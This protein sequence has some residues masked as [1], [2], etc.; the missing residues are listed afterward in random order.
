[1][2]VLKPTTT[3][4]PV[5]DLTWLDKND[6]RVLAFTKK[7]GVEGGGLWY[8]ED[9]AT[10]WVNKTQALAD[11]SGTDIKEAVEVVGI[12]TP[13][14]TVGVVRTGSVVVFGTGTVIW[15]SSDYGATYT[16]K[17]TGGWRGNA[18]KMIKVHPWHAD[19]MLVLAKRPNCTNA[20]HALVECPHDLMLTQ[21]LYGALTWQNLTQ[22]SNGKIAGFVDFDW[23][24]Q[25]CADR[26]DPKPPSPTPSEY[27]IDCRKF[28]LKD[29][30]VLATMYEKPG[31]YDHP[32]DKDVH[33]VTTHDLFSNH[34]VVVRCGNM[35]EVIGN[36]VFLA[37]S[38]SCPTDIDGSP[39]RPHQSFSGV[40][41]YTS[42]D[43]AVS[44]EQGCVPVALKQE[45][46]EMLT[47]HDSTGVQ[48]IVDFKVGG[49]KGPSLFASS[50]YTAGPRDAIYT[51]S[52]TNVYR[53]PM[54]MGS[55]YARVEGLPG[56]YIA[57]QLLP[58][59]GDDY[60]YDIDTGA[61][62]VESR[63][64]F[65]G[66]G[67]WARIPAPKTFNSAKCNRCT[68]PD[69]FLHLRGTSTWASASAS[70]PAVYS[71]P[72]APGI[73]MATGV[74]ASSGGGLEDDD[75][76]L[77]TWLSTDGGISWKD[78]A[79]G[80]WVYEYADFGSTIVM[81]RHSGWRGEAAD[82]V[83]FSVDN[84]ACWYSVPLETAMFVE[85][86][87]IEPD[88][89]RPRVVVHGSAC[90][91]SV[92][93]KCSLDATNRTSASVPGIMYMV[94]VQELLAGKMSQCTEAEYEWWFV[95]ESSG[96][97]SAK[98]FL[99]R[100]TYIRR[101]GES[102]L[103]FNGPDWVRPPSLS[104]E[105]CACTALDVECDYG[106][107]RGPDGACALLPP[108]QMPVCPRVFERKYLVSETGL[109]LIHA[110]ACTGLTTL[111]PDTDGQGT[112][113]V[114]FCGDLPNE[115]ERQH[116]WAV[117]VGHLLFWTALAGGVFAWWTYIAS[118]GQR[119]WIQ[120]KAMLAAELAS[121]AWAKIKNRVRPGR[122]NPDDDL[123][124]FQPLA[125]VPA[126]DRDASPG[127]FTL[128]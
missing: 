10:T 78:A 43:G 122:T 28:N 87:R 92:S 101:R 95:P 118:R 24:A 8:S 67:N 9:G 103:C 61:P 115:P 40:V 52:L 38:N 112:C 41:L 63:I 98:C 88:G 22:R 35:F 6:Q 66:G 76:G 29:E 49:G 57:N 100:K 50:V 31:D 62:L 77:C 108:D 11:A 102:K 113:I 72:S 99:G 46:Y 4:S 106:Y 121:E 37:Y 79:E 68:G 15:V 128:R 70:M 126:S 114:A 117:V 7:T 26:D 94:D 75:G 34:K 89:Q 48:I 84:G 124:Y 56:V 58:R 25:L 2:D 30:T 20:D 81:A 47:T 90:D 125:E 104:N 55:D 64:T 13:P 36:S 51:L 27:A 109:R 65:N 44:F 82:E 21:D 39:R 54:G 16:S 3:T 18:V 59:S 85:N 73:V 107:T 110:D 80:S 42:V 71:S 12:F 111:I 32:W 69:C 96:S 123:G 53:A 1:M 74:S 14:P 23:G 93:D 45:G 19:W 91:K 105:V 97:K 17:R 33:F 120:D 116:P 86:I 60:E 127:I 119:D 83:R 5:M